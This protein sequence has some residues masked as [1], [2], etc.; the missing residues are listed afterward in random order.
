M[1]KL[2]L[3]SKI[4]E[5]GL[6]YTFIADKLGISEAALVKKRQGNIPFKVSEIKILK[7][8]LNLSD[9]EVSKIFL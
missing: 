6:K 5:C 4:T 9:R 2:L 1:D 8:L 7:K 3:D